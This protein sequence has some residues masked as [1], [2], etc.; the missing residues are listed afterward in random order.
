MSARLL[1]QFSTAT[2]SQGIGHGRAST[3]VSRVSRPRTGISTVAG[4]SSQHIVC[5]VSESRGVS[6]IVG[7]AFV[8]LDSCETTLCQICDSQ[9]YVR[10]I[11]KLHVY[12]PSEILVVNTASDPKSKLLSF[13]EDNLNDIGSELVLID[14]RY[15]AESTG[16]ENLQQLALTDDIEAIK[17]AIAG[18]YFAICCFAAALSYIEHNHGLSFHYHTLR[19]K[20]EPS[21]GSMMIDVSTI[22]SLEL[23]QNLR[24]AKSRDCLFGLLN[25]T[26]TPMGARLLRNNI[27]QPLTDAGTLQLRYDA[28]EELTT[29]EEMFYSIPMQNFFDVDKLLTSLIL[30]PRNPK[31]PHVEHGINSN[32]MLKHF[33]TSVKPIR[34]ALIGA[35]SDLLSGIRENCNPRH[36]NP[37][38]TL[39]E[40]VLNDD[41]KYSRNPL[42]MRNQRTYAVQAGV[43]GLLDAARQTYKENLDDAIA[44]QKELEKRCE[45]SLELKYDSV[46]HYYIRFRQADIEGREMPADFVNIVRKK[47]K[48]ECQTLFLAKLNSKKLTDAIRSHLPALFKVCE[49]LAMLDMLSG[50]AQLATSQ[51]YV[52]PQLD[53]PAPLDDGHQSATFAVEAGRHP[54]K[55]KIQKTKFVP[56]DIYATQQTRFQI[57]TGCNMSGKST[58]IRSIALMAVMAQIGSF[59]PA[60]YAILPIHYQLF[61]RISVDDS[62]QANMSTFAA[63]MQE[64]AFILR[65]VDKR[66]IA[67][68]DE[69]GR[70]TS[71]RDG[72]AIA[73]AITEALV[74]SRVSSSH[75][76]SDVKP[77]DNADTF[78]ALVWFVTHFTELAAIMA[79]RNGV[80]NLH[81]A[82]DSPNNTTMTMLYRVSPGPT[83]REL[84]GLTLARLVPL[85]PSVLSH[86]EIVAQKLQLKERGRGGLSAGDNSTL[87][88][89]RRRKLILDLREHLIQAQKGRMEGELLKEW[90][91]GL[92]REFVSRMSDLGEQS[93]SIED[94]S[95]MGT[96]QEGVS[97]LSDGDQ[98]SM[99]HYESDDERDANNDRPYHTTERDT[100]FARPNTNNFAMTFEDAS[101][102]SSVGSE[103]VEPVRLESSSRDRGVFTIHSQS[104]SMPE[105]VVSSDEM[106]V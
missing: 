49:S 104:A 24:N 15:W 22:L 29:K 52:R 58:Y 17:S 67:I 81:L 63:E 96:V 106:L 95:E 39:I 91:T 32:I 76:A 74:A 77:L 31:L 21:E 10:T 83:S 65:N 47:D 68:I 37:V 48:I 16:W 40:S 7:L 3:A 66:S 86:A 33:V 19:I 14:R 50:F 51:N 6:P 61:A 97:E 55:E 103:T 71:S 64:T 28:L 5:A 23:I 80:T 18:N 8:N 82:V 94:P 92:Q 42:D 38:E 41:I 57:I 2:T 46:R 98:E 13:I 36:I 101:A 44:Y 26:Q 90:L 25:E 43:N 100:L 35:S 78:Q 45:I 87:L 1:A 11:Q 59:V 62:T 73:I 89:Q 84:Y 20:Y 93:G 72:L 79:E 27:L 12:E 99:G 102:S 69:L 85:P 34:D 60:K 105:T 75:L 4:L 9:T 30:V 56:N 88:V 70:G 53:E 54:I